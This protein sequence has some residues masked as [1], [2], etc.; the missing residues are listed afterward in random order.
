MKFASDPGESAIDP[1]ALSPYAGKR[2]KQMSG[3]PLR[4]APLL[5]ALLVVFWLVACSGESQA[6]AESGEAAGE[7][8]A[9]E[10]GAAG[11]G[12]EASGEHQG[13]G[14]AQEGG[15]HSEGGGGPGGWRA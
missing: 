4:L 15:G 9:M 2:L 11:G 3:F 8:A 14:E 13:S 5:T 6:D 1:K 7:H 12:A 10:V